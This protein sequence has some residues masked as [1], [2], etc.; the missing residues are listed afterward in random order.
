M[1]EQPIP[2]P[3]QDAAPHKNAGQAPAREAIYDNHLVKVIGAPNAAGRIKVQWPDPRNGLVERYVHEGELTFMD[4]KLPAVVLELVQR[5]H[6][7]F[8]A[9]HRVLAQQY[10]ALLRKI[11]A[12]TQKGEPFRVYSEYNAPTS[13]RLRSDC[14]VL[15]RGGLLEGQPVPG[16]TDYRLSSTGAAALGV[17]YQSADTPAVIAQAEAVVKA[18]TARQPVEVRTLLQRGILLARERSDADRELSEH[19]NSGWR[20]M[21]MQVLVVGDRDLIRVVTLQRWPEPEAAPPPD[22]RA[23]VEVPALTDEAEPVEEPLVMPVGPTVIITGARQ[24][25]PVLHLGPYGRSIRDSG[26]DETL[27]IADQAAAEKGRAA[28]EKALAETSI[29]VRPLIPAGVNHD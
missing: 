28:F 21:D 11:H 10:V 27:A 5:V 9:N 16:A 23:G 6:K 29:P 14:A 15:Q 4:E 18:A 26:L 2:I 25:E 22:V 20:L 13:G 19:L 1:T 17:E 3:H 7:G 12:V 24:P 8:E